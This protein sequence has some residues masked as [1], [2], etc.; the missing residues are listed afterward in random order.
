MMKLFISLFISLLLF[1]SYESKYLYEPINGNDI[2][3]LYEEDVCYNEGGKK[4]YKCEGDNF[5]VNS[6]CDGTSFIDY[7]GCDGKSCKCSS[8]LSQYIFV[9]VYSAAGCSESNLLT[10][11]KVDGGCV[12]LTNLYFDLSVS[13]ND[14]FTL[15]KY[16]SC[17]RGDP[18]DS[19]ITEDTDKCITMEGNYFKVRAAG[20]DDNGDDDDKED[21][22]SNAF[23]ITAHSLAL[24]IL[25]LMAMLL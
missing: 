2:G 4:Q 14:E 24:L 18:I 22:S 11:Y 6:G 5:Q 13:S 8:S 17:S 3:Y 15:T 20:F 25:S 10:T 23:D 1:H 7:E 16:E 12:S 19:P 21:S 9:D